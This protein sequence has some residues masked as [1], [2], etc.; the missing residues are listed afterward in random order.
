MEIYIGNL[1][2]KVSKEDLKNTFE[3]YGQIATIKFKKDLFS[4]EPKGYAFITM[5]VQSE[6]EKAIEKL[7]GKKLKG[8]EITVKEARSHDHSWEKGR[9]KKKGRPF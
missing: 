9:T 3:K 6:A 2:K 4:G 7:D 5:T 1:S 8:Q